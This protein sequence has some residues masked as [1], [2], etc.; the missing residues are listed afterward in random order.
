[1]SKRVLTE[2]AMLSAMASQSGSGFNYFTGNYNRN[3]SPTPCKEHHN[4]AHLVNQSKK[5]R[6]GAGHRKLTRA[7]RK[8]NRL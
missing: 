1:M 5:L 6:K 2:M 7:E 8:R 3:Y 4:V